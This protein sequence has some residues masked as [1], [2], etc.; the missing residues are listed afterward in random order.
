MPLTRIAPGPPSASTRL[1]PPHPSLR[2]LA[3]A[4]A[5][6]S[7]GCQEPVSP[8]QRLSPTSPERLL[9]DAA[10]IDLREDVL[11]PGVRA[12]IL[13]LSNN[14]AMTG[15][16]TPGP[17]SQRT[18]YRMMPGTGITGIL[19]LPGSTAWGWDINDAGVVVGIA[20]FDQGRR[21]AVVATGAAMVDLGLLPGADP[22]GN[23]EAMAIN[24]AGQIVGSSSAGSAD[25]HAVLWEPSGVIRDLGGSS[26]YAIDINASGLVIGGS[27]G[28][29]VLWTPSGVMQDLTEQLGF[30]GVVAINDAGQIVGQ[31]TTSGGDSHAALY[32]PGTGLHDLGTLGGKSSFVSGLNNRGQAVG[33]S[34][35]PDGRFHAFFWEADEG[36]QD[37]TLV[38]G[39]AW[40]GVTEVRVLNDFLQTLIG[41]QPF[42]DPPRVGNLGVVT[43]ITQSI[44][45]TTQAPTDA[46]PGGT[47]VV[48]AVATSRLP[49]T[50]T[51]LSPGVCSVSGA[52]VAFLDYGS[53]VVAADQSGNMN[54]RPAARVTLTIVVAW[55]FELVKPTD[56]P[57]AF[58][59]LQAGRAASITF[60]LGGDRG[61]HLFGEHPPVSAEVSCTTGAVLGA[62]AAVPWDDLE[63]RYHP[64]PDRYVLSW[65]TS[66]TWEGSCRQL[67]LP[68]VDGST[69]V[70]L[71]DFK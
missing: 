32:T 27:G 6:I 43:R 49:V 16:W 42:M 24:A 41:G 46:R 12:N 18:A 57:P 34:E 7:L 66:E 64:G 44:S 69:R 29:A 63:L 45:F 48:E 38:G 61:V 23:S 55:P 70:V 50:F 60:G 14:G 37:I 40:S 47:F 54:W 8:L 33:S 58:N 59:K 11:P 26:S 22:G 36:M 5:L 56:A 9:I 2:V 65:R 21:R 17:E 31:I 68:F 35:T 71:F 13:G 67:M 15:S 25:R 20:Q 10:I 39:V 28:H 19:P 51:S 30:T 4:C 1:A 53:C 3:A 52:T 62:P